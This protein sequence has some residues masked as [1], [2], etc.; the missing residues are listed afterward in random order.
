MVEG[1]DED[2]CL[3]K[4]SARRGCTGAGLLGAS[5]RYPRML[6]AARLIILRRRQV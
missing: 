4:S 3:P 1:G 5:H 2:F 6:P